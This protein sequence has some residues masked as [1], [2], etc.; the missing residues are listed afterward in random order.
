VKIRRWLRWVV[1]A[2]ALAA[3]VAACGST[4]TSSKPAAASSPQPTSEPTSGSAAQKQITDNWTEFFDPKTPVDRRIALLQDGQTFAPVI[5]SQ[6]GSA[7]AS[8]ASASVSKVAVTS[9]NQAAVGYSILLAGKPVLA[10]QSGNAV[11]QDGMWKVGASS[12][13]GLLTVESGGSAVSLPAACKAS[14]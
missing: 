1:V 6:A 3:A 8:Q 10:N 7:L 12:F 13:C 4:S 9:A 5:K 14:P 2:F 11:Y